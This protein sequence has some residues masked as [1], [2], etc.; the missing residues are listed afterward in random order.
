MR[1]LS[2]RITQLTFLH[3]SCNSI[4]AEND[5]RPEPATGQCTAADAADRS[6]SDSQ[7]D[8]RSAKTQHHCRIAL[9]ECARLSRGS[10][11]FSAYYRVC[12]A[13]EEGSN[14]TA[15]VY[16]RA[17]P[18]VTP[19]PSHVLV[20]SYTYIHNIVGSLILCACATYIHTHAAS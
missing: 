20:F 8:Y 3:A 11:N 7:R 15:R 14:R 16:L 17:N 10:D 13:V 6:E 9:A 1:E 19:L 12:T 4:T 18:L 5:N 2:P